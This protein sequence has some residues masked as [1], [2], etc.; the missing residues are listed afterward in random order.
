MVI[1]EATRVTWHE[2]FEALC[3][4]IGMVNRYLAWSLDGMPEEQRKPVDRANDFLLIVGHVFAFEGFCLPYVRSVPDVAWRPGGL[5]SGLLRRIQKR[6]SG[7]PKA[8]PLS[9]VLAAVDP[10]FS[11]RHLYAHPMGR[12]AGLEH[13][14][15]LPPAVLKDYGFETDDKEDGLAACWWPTRFTAFRRCVGPLMELA[16][17]MAQAWGDP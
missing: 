9:P 11:I 3:E 4:Q 5:N 10:V 1:S 2:E 13:P 15:N 14:A 17:M 12:R 16:S 7:D 6:A 8:C